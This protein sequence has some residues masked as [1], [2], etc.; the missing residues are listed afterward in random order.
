MERLHFGPGNRYNG[1]EAAVHIARYSFVKG[2]CANKR[3]L[4]IACGEGYGS[5]LMSQWGATEVHGVDIS[6][7]SVENA[8]A[9]F[10]SPGLHYATGDAASVGKLFESQK[11][12]LIVSLE[13]IEHVAEPEQ[14]LASIKA[15]LAP[16]GA[17]VISCPNDWWYYPSDEH[18]NPYHLRKYHLEEFVAQTESVLGKASGWFLG[19]PLTGFCNLRLDGYGEAAADDDQTLMVRQL[20][21]MPSTVVPAEAGAGPRPQNASYFIGVW[22][23]DPAAHALSNPGGLTILPLSMDAFRSGIFQGHCPEGSEESERKLAALQQ[24]LDEKTRLLHHQVLKLTAVQME[25]EICRGALAAYPPHEELHML[26]MHAQRYR[27]LKRLVPKSLHVPLWKLGQSL[28][29]WLR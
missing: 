24:Q 15:L 29:G 28:K 4:D 16:G 23:D 19:G 2:A 27:R 26:Y 8:K 7:E 3:V 13:T 25:L 9:H 10:Q 1:L 22:S 18:K 11:F 12:D 5:Y 6:P 14:F 21:A 17:I 20:E